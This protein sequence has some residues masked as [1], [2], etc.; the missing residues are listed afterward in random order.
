M[1]RRNGK[2]T[3]ETARPGALRDFVI[4]RTRKHIRGSL[5]ADD[6]GTSEG[7]KRDRK[8]ELGKK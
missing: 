4:W 3:A 6:E 1:P 5:A 8:E 2:K 7:E